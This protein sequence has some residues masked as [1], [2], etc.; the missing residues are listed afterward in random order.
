MNESNKIEILLV[1][2]SQDDLDMTLRALR[3]SN[4]TNHIQ[5]A[6]DGEEALE[7]IFCEGAHAGRKFENPPKVILLDLKLPKIDGMEVLKRIKGD[8][9]TK[10][11]PV[12]MLTSSKEQRDVIG[13]YNLGVNSYIVKPVNFEGF[14]AAVQEV[15]MYWL[16]HNQP[17]KI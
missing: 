5:V 1:E 7:F 16:L 3:K 6:R 2:D 8:E 17:P 12:V 4:L 14:A 11:V 15:G 10:M 9:R 13:S